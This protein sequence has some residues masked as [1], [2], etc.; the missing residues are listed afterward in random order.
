MFLVFFFLIIGLVAYFGY[1]YND[2]MSL[3]NKI[4]EEWQSMCTSLK[5]RFKILE[6][7]MD[8]NKDLSFDY[9]SVK[10]LMEKLQTVTSKEEFVP[11]YQSF[12]NKLNEFLK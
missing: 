9:Q 12:E 1:V 5:D 2:F 11:L 3:Q 6:E 7:L 4:G 10:D 8:A